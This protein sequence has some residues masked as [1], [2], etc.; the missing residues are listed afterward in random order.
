MKDQIHFKEGN[1][2]RKPV[3]GKILEKVNASMHP[4]EY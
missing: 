1:M 4:P 3:F 2:K